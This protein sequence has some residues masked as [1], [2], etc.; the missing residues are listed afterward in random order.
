MEGGIDASTESIY[1]KKLILKK[2]YCASNY[3]SKKSG[4]HPG[5]RS[6]LDDGMLSKDL[7]VDNTK[8]ATVPL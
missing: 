5:N 4:M 1:D 8:T 7:L 2:Q 6:I 3:C